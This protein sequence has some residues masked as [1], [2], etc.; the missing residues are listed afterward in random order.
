MKEQDL[1]SCVKEHG[2]MINFSS[3]RVSDGNFL[4]PGGENTAFDRL[5]I[6]GNKSNIVDKNLA[7]LK[8]GGALDNIKEIKSEVSQN[9]N[10]DGDGVGNNQQR[11]DE[12]CDCDHN[13]IFENTK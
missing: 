11:D 12:L 9:M 6:P 2:K 7:Y 8:P 4:R 13:T 1:F 5:Q 10:Q 3:K